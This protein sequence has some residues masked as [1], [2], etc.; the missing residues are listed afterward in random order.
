MVGVDA[1]GYRTVN[2]SELPYLLLGAVRELKAENDALQARL[3]T[4]TEQL[5]AENAAFRPSSA[6]KPLSSKR[7]TMRCN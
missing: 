7:K 1:H 2:Y 3:S 5:K 4:E 6:R